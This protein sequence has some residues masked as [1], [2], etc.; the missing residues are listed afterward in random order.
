MFLSRLPLAR[1]VIGTSMAILL[2][3]CSSLGV[4]YS[5][6]Q[7]AL[8]S[9]YVQPSGGTA[10]VTPETR[11][12]T[13]LGDKTLNALITEGLA[14]NISV[15]QALE[16]VAQARA[17]ARVNGV[18][19]DPSVNGSASANASGNTAASGITTSRTAIIDASWEV[20]FFGTA[21]RNK[22]MQQA[23]VDAAVEGANEARLTLIGDITRT[24]V[25]IRSYQRRLALAKA[26]LKTQ[27]ATTDVVQKQFD[28]GTSTALAVAQSEG[29]SQS[30]A[31]SI[32]TL[33]VALQQ[34][35]NVLAVLLGQQ[36]AEL[37]GKLDKSNGIPRVKTAIGAGIP[38]DLIRNRPDIRQ[39]ERQLAAAVEKI[40]ITEASL[41]PSLTLAGS[42]TTN[43]TL[44][45][46]S[47]GPTL[48]LPIFNRDKLQGNVDLAQSQARS[49]YLSY[50][51]T[52]LS[53][54]QDV[55]DAIVAYVKEKT[56]R[57]ALAS[58]VASYTKAADLSEQLYKAGTADYSEVLT[59]Q[60]SLQSAQ[61]SLAQSEATLA[62]AYITLAK[63]LGGG[64]AAPTK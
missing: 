55:E 10:A 50:R 53:A 35:I 48:T 46:W 19:Y 7:L 63:S 51:A 8:T 43:G 24:Y 1:P 6:P 54:V 5:E 52:V 57:T 37:S 15:A 36:P 3:G 4:T 29:Q 25:E 44:G 41:Y 22:A 38:A 40:G 26:S 45:S 47:L 64:W 2:A 27:Q 20:D 9:H 28:A 56:R 12:W 61:D 18:S 31:A 58:A 32:P 34:S 42:L 49:A 39:S 30:T 62:T 13:A 14:Q 59:A 60:R 11:W 23:N 17:T 21:K 33:E 16:L